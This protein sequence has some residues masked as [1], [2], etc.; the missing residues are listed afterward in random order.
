M[1]ALGDMVGDL[2]VGAAV[3][4]FLVGAVLATVVVLLLQRLF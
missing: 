2:I 4:A 1:G 3:A